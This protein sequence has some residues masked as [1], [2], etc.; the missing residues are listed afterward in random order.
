MHVFPRSVVSRARR[1]ASARWGRLVSHGLAL[2]ALSCADPQAPSVATESPRPP[3]DAGPTA[4][5]TDSASYTLRAT[6]TGYTADIRVVFTNPTARPVYV[7]N[8]LG[9][10]M[11]WLERWTGG[12]WQ[13]VW[14]PI[15]PA[16]LSAPIVV[17][18]GGDYR[19]VVGIDDCTVLGSCGPQFA[20]LPRGERHRL[21]WQNLVTEY[22]ATVPRWGAPLRVDQRRS[23][24]FVLHTPPR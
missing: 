21:V 11:L 5:R 10:T 3:E 13:I 18:G 2:G 24:V 6:S 19:S 7:V 9:A 1:T 8:C 4:F 14:S 23:N 20:S 16:C 15:I 22:D 12:R 17:A